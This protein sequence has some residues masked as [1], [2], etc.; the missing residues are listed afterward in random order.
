M[1]ARTLATVVE[2]EPLSLRELAR[3]VGAEDRWIVQLVEVEILH[4]DAPTS[5]A[6]STRAASNATSARTST[7]RH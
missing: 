6:P 5:S 2:S 3:A 1:T 7:P 4:V